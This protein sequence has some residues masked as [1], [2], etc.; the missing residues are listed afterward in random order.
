ME[1]GE[2]KLKVFVGII[3]S[4]DVVEVMCARKYSPEEQR[5]STQKIVRMIRHQVNMAVS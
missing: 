3:S 2:T 4:K 5:I 1:V